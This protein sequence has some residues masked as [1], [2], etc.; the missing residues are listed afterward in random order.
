MKAEREVFGS[1][2]K[3]YENDHPKIK[4][5][6]DEYKSLQYDQRRDLISVFQDKIDILQGQIAAAEGLKMKQIIDNINL[7][8]LTIEKMQK[9][10]DRDEEVA[11]LKGGGKLSRIEEWQKNQVEYTRKKKIEKKVEDYGLSANN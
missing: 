1:N 9:E 10:I 11:Q 4:E 7:V 8:N 6:I 2:T 5:A 3:D